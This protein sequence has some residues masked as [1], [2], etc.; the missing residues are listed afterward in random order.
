MFGFFA[1]IMKAF[2]EIAKYKIQAVIR[3]SQINSQARFCFP[4]ECNGCLRPPGF[5]KELPPVPIP[6]IDSLGFRQLAIGFISCYATLPF[7]SSF[8]TLPFMDEIF[9]LLSH[10]N[11]QP[12]YVSGDAEE[13]WFSLPLIQRN[14]D[15]EEFPSLPFQPRELEGG[16][17]RGRKES[18]YSPEWRQDCDIQHCD[19]LFSYNFLSGWMMPQDEWMF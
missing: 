1:R 12:T 16:I 13:K 17:S 9:F 3:N 18:P 11:M 5:G 19:L 4:M 8:A 14:W 6:I 7:K 15:V 2:E 10:L